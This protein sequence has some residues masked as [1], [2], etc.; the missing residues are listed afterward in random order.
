MAK[1]LFRLESV[2]KTYA[3]LLHRLHIQTKRFPSLTQ[4][5]ALQWAHTFNFSKRFFPTT[6]LSSSSE[7]TQSTRRILLY[8]FYWNTNWN[9]NRLPCTRV[10]SMSGTKEAVERWALSCR[11]ES[12]RRGG[13]GTGHRHHIWLAFSTL[14]AASLSFPTKSCKQATSEQPT[15]M[16]WNTLWITPFRNKN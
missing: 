9:D 11:W 4:K 15:K 10:T 14:L 3:Q 12:E 13:E 1:I 2:A 5:P 8:L 16:T 7:I 6:I